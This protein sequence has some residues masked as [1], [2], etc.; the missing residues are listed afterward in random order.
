MIMAGSRM[1]LDHTPLGIS[2]HLRLFSLLHLSQ[3]ETR[4]DQGRL[5]GLSQRQSATGMGRVTSQ[6]E[7]R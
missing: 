1:H 5:L 7:P 2:L 4:I 6:T 3:S